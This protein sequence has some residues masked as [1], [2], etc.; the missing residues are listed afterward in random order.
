M[1]H[2]FLA[3]TYIILAALTAMKPSIKDVEIF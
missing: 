3:M 1:K 2:D